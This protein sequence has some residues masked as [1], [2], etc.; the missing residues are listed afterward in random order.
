MSID[1]QI[2]YKAMKLTIDQI[3]DNIQE[4]SQLTEADLKI[5]SVAKLRKILSGCGAHNIDRDGETVSIN[6]ARKA[7]LID[8][9]LRVTSARRIVNEVA[10]ELSDAQLVD[11][12][13]VAIEEFM[14]GTGLSLLE[15]AKDSFKKLDSATR[16]EWDV[17]NQCWLPPTRE[18]QNIATGIVL[19]MTNR[20][21]PR[22]ESYSA[23]TN[24]KQM[25]ELKRIILEMS[26]TTKGEHHYKRL[27]QNIDSVFRDVSKVMRQQADMLKQQDSIA[28][29]EKMQS[30]AGVAGVEMLI[31]RAQLTLEMLN[32]E[33]PARKWREV[34][35]ALAIVTG[36]RKAEIQALA[37]FEV[38]GD[39][40]VLFTGQA[41][42]K[43][44][45]A[46]YFAENPSYVIPTLAPAKDVV[47][48]L[49]WLTDNGK[50]ISE[51]EAETP[52]KRAKLAHNRYSK[53]LSKEA[54][55]WSDQT[56]QVVMP[57]DADKGVKHQSEIGYHHFRK[58]YALV[59]VRDRKPDN[60]T[61]VKYGAMILGHGEYDTST[62]D[63]YNADFYLVNP[64]GLHPSVESSGLEAKS[65]ASRSPAVDS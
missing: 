54:L 24:L 57:S 46:D 55:K 53:D 23:L 56:L 42:T 65:S 32:D 3:Q 15:I 44:A 6:K 37:V 58:L 61:A 10:P 17:D 1:Y 27:T 8:A 22:G 49:N 31:K 18:V 5:E 59:C 12:K 35:V 25:S 45:T 2:L 34:S 30:L 14:S 26:E 63:R 62:I 29:N 9:C 41:K 39:D 43:G 16:D 36:R 64:K 60:I 47:K 28:Q 50:R 51:D 4:L 21:T 11:T 48:G 19:A 20:K 52:Q 40:E 38:A 7:E 13:D 33:T